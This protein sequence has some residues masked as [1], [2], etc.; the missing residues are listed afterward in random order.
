[1]TLLCGLLGTMK[2]STIPTTPHSAENIST[3]RKEAPMPSLKA[4]PYI[5]HDQ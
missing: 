5:D 1:M 2:G 3:G 4:H